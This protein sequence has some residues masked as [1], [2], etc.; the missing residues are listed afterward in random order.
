MSTKLSDY[1]V[2]ACAWVR[3]VKYVKLLPLPHIRIIQNEKEEC[4][5][6]FVDMCSFYNL[7]ALQLSS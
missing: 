1:T 7:D 3:E 5:L 6:F 4:G 2:R